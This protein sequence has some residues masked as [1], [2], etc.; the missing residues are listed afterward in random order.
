MR[1]LLYLMLALFLAAASAAAVRMWTET[2]G[3]ITASRT[4]QKEPEK[5]AKGVL[6]AAKELTTGS[7]VQPDSVR[8][9]EWPDVA[10]P[11]TYYVRG[12]RGEDDIAGA[13]VRRPIA[14]GEPIADGN[15]VKPGERGFLAAV[16]DPGMRAI[17]VAVDD[18]SSNAGLIFP[19]DRVDLILTQTIELPEGSG[20][21]RASETVLK[22]VRVIAM[23]Q[24]LTSEAAAESSGGKRDTARTAT[25]EVTPEHAERVALVSEL[26]KLSLSLRSLAAGTELMPPPAD[27]PR[28]TWDSDASAVLRRDSQPNS[29]LTVVRGE[30]A[31]KISIQRGA[32]S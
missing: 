7:F 30:K 27:V 29:S 24:A 10:T 28:Y 17:S 5:E 26:G 1:R 2:Q 21:R 6:V 18:T 14:A 23:G 11:E 8:W 9:Q 32:G 19:G 12:Q 15:L 31:E 13:V 4:E 22:D 16:L 25:L 3:K 20:S